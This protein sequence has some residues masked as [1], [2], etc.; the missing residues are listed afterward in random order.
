MI[1][2]CGRD[3]HQSLP[4]LNHSVEL[5]LLPVFNLLVGV[6]LDELRGFCCWYDVDLVRTVLRRVD[7]SHTCL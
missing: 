7:K 3:I 1:D 6:T 5:T 4:L 2:V